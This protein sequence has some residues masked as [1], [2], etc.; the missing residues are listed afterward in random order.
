MNRFSSLKL[1]WRRFLRHEYI[2][3]YFSSLLA[4]INC[5]SP[6]EKG[7]SDVYVYV[8][9]LYM[10][11]LHVLYFLLS[12]LSKAVY[13]FVYSNAYTKGCRSVRMWTVGS[14]FI[15]Q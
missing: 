13:L 10:K 7:G 15:G 6:I 4:L 12:C 3:I 2:H 1:I 14:L 5:I 8:C 9:I 11:G